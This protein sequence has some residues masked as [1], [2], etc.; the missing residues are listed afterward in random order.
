MAKM[1]SKPFDTT[2]KHLVELRPRDVL[3]LAGVT[4]V[5]DARLVDADLASI[6]AAAD[7]VLRVRT[8]SGEFLVHFE[9]QSGRDP[10][11]VERIFWYNAALTYRH[12]LP[13]QTVVVLLA[14]PA[15]VRDLQGT[16]V[17]ALPNGRACLTF[18]YDMIRLWLMPADAI[19]DGPIGILPMALLC[20]EKGKVEEIIA[21]MDRRIEAEATPNEAAT[22]WAATYFLMG[23]RFDTDTV[24]NLLPK[25]KVM[26]ESTT[27]QATLEEGRQEGR[28]EE[29]IRLLVRLGRKTLGT[30]G[31]RV[32][33]HL[34]SLSDVNVIESLVERINEAASWEELLPSSESTPRKSR[35]KKR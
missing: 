3:A 2:C 11:L 20:R 9:F 31:T 18:H 4:D 29:A 5:I 16:R 34:D 21:K 33:E 32:R 12:G 1:K 26:K 35:K 13:V 6:V 14:P 10:E 19:L 25:G 15:D 23:L 8:A 7:K 27:Y 24:A 28:Q 30:P 22:L 17:F